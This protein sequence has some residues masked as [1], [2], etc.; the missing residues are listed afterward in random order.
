[1]S[2]LAEL[3]RR[4][5]IRM[6]GLYLVGAWL[7]VQIAETLLPIFHTPYWV[8]QTLVVLLALG[9]VPVLVFSWIYELTPE[10][11]RRE[12]DLDHSRPASDPD[13]RGHTTTHDN[14]HPRIRIFLQ[15]KNWTVELC[16][17]N[18]SLNPCF[19]CNTATN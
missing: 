12:R 5:V 18:S 11:L 16:E 2:F 17:R 8:L 15:V 4:N 1:M 19:R 3:R 10:G 9:F 6:A 7:L 14:G 13:K